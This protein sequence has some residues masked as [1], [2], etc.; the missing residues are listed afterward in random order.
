MILCMTTRRSIGSLSDVT[1]SGARYLGYI[2]NR[3]LSVIGAVKHVLI[4]MKGIVEFVGKELTKKH[5]NLTVMSFHKM[6][7]LGFH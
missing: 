3:K 5:K 1:D 6:E 7:G 2:Q 4:T